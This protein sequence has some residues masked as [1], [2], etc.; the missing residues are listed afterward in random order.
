M[1]IRNRTI[2]VLTAISALCA[3][4]IWFAYPRGPKITGK[5]SSDDLNAISDLVY[6]GIGRR[7][8][9]H[10]FSWLALRA[11]PENISH[12]RGRIISIAASEDAVQVEAL[13]AYR[14]QKVQPPRDVAWGVTYIL[15]KNSQNS[16]N[17]WEIAGSKVWIGS[18]SMR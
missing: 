3:F 9:L 2:I 14:P 17:T 4:W 7:P 1:T 12:Y 16:T 8:I 10:N 6:Q 5:I 11:I 18:E 15:R 13:L